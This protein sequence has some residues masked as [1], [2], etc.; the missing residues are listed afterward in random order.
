MAYYRQARGGMNIGGARIPVVVLK[1]NNTGYY[2]F[3]DGDDFLNILSYAI[4]AGWPDDRKRADVF[5]DEVKNYN[6]FKQYH[7]VPKP[8]KTKK[9]FHY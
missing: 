5:V 1:A 7:P 6:P 3:L 4:Q 8:V 9:P 2:V